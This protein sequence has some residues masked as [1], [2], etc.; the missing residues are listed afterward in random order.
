MIKSSKEQMQ[1]D[2]TRVLAEL[3]KNSNKNIDRIAKSVGFSKQKVWRIIKQLEEER[4]IWGYSAITDAKKQDLEKYILFF[5]RSSLPFNEKTAEEMNVNGMFNDYSKLGIAIETSYYIHGEYD[6]VIIFTAKDI[7][8]AKKFVNLMQNRYPGLIE[9]IQLAR[10]L[11][12]PRDHYI[13][14]PAPLKAKDIV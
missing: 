14:N 3:Q 1:K 2:A 12:T 5:K 11:Y 6:W 8:Y 13:I 4:F 10:V 7:I 9:K